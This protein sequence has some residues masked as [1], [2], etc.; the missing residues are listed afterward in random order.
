MGCVEP[1]CPAA[2]YQEPP[3]NR[4]TVVCDLLLSENDPSGRGSCSG[5]QVITE[6]VCD[7]VCDCVCDRHATEVFIV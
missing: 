7:C 5:A 1:G 3:R 6:R 4:C 2:V